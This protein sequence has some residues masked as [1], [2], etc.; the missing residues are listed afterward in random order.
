MRTFRLF[1]IASGLMA[2]TATAQVQLSL[3]EQ[4]YVLKQA[5]Q[6]VTVLDTDQDGIPN[7]LDPDDD[8]DGV[9]DT[10]DAFPL[11]RTEWLDTDGDGI[12]NNADPDDDNDG[13][14]DVSDDLPLDPTESRDQDGDGVGDN[15]DQFD[16]DAFCW[17]QQ[18]GDANGCY[19][20]QI[21]D[22]NLTGMNTYPY[23]SRWVRQ[24]DSDQ[25]HTIVFIDQH[26]ST[27]YRFDLK[28]KTLTLKEKLDIPSDSPLIVRYVASHKKFY[29]LAEDSHRLLSLTIDG[30]AIQQEPDLAV[31]GNN[32]IDAGRFLIVYQ[33]DGKLQLMDA[34]GPFGAAKSGTDSF[35]WRGRTT[36]HPVL[37]QLFGAGSQTPR[38]HIH[39]Q[40]G[41]ITAL[42]NHHNGRYLHDEIAVSVRGDRLITSRGQVFDT[43][44][45]RWQNNFGGGN[46][47]QL[48]L[49]DD[50]LVQ[51]TVY[52]DRKPD[53]QI[54]ATTYLT[55]RNATGD[56]QEAFH[57]PGH[58]KLLLAAAKL[59]LALYEHNGLLQPK[60]YV[61]SDDTD[62]DGIAN[63]QDDFP[64]DA[65][66][67]KDTDFDGAPD[68]WNP[69]MTQA[70]STTGLMLDAFP[71]QAACQHIP[72]ANASGQCDLTRFHQSLDW[73]KPA[74]RFFHNGILYLFSAEKQLIYRWS[75][76]SQQVM[77]PLVIRD[78]FQQHM[79]Q[80]G[81]L[82]A[83]LHPSHQTVYLQSY[84]GQV[85]SMPL[86]GGLPSFFAGTGSMV[87]TSNSLRPLMQ[88]GDY[89]VL[90][91]PGN[92]AH[93]VYHHSFGKNRQ[94]AGTLH[95]INSY[96]AVWS[97]QRQTLV[98]AHDEIEKSLQF[99]AIAPGGQFTNFG[100][101]TKW[102]L[103]HHSEDQP[104][105]L[106]EDGSAVLS[107]TGYLIELASPRKLT[108]LADIF[109]FSHALAIG[110]QFLLAE[111]NQLMFYNRL[112]LQR[113]SSQS[114]PGPIVQLYRHHD[115]LFALYQQDQTLVVYPIKA[116][117]AAPASP[118]L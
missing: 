99:N 62:Q 65:A 3:A 20:S 84:T 60:Y 36:Y 61:A 49:A 104:L 42:T 41:E 64:N 85:T 48:W 94:L 74:S 59:Q 98:Y 100:Y 109:Y 78:K 71:A 69:G 111:G 50:S 67:S 38:V 18:D 23:A 27:V 25:Q 75:A 57:W 115:W 102:N 82:Y 70:H 113:L 66:A 4:Y 112:T 30:S 46:A 95:G 52:R 96:G 56:I 1:W 22:L 6:T 45:L 77:D 15:R 58:A 88:G 12:G 55:R 31:A 5:K 44:S 11:D 9:P 2:T 7:Q 35:Y 73:S 24:V 103:W 101:D 37:Q 92:D 97:A 76:A 81:A 108:R 16:L 90:Q 93:W 26:R 118:S 43:H 28:S 86:T 107:N 87:A 14:P 68:G 19:L 10:Q 34:D 91:E 110:N 80:S 29:L 8:N 89:L 33:T 79:L 47:G 21:K 116:A 17:N 106:T 72:D 40:T 13:V 63:T 105:F 114:L 51:L 83:L 53:G 32:L 117:S 39:Q 54:N